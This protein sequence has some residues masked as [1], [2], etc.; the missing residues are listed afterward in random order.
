MLQHSTFK[1]FSTLIKEGS[2]EALSVPVFDEDT[3]L[4]PEYTTETGWHFYAHLNITDEL[5]EDVK[6]R[7]RIAAIYDSY[8]TAARRMLHDRS[9]FVKLLEHQGQMLHFHVD[10]DNS[11]IG[12]NILRGLATLLA[13]Y[14]YEEVFAKR[15]SDPAVD[16]FAMA[17]QYGSSLIFSVPPATEEESAYSQISLGSCA[18]DPAKVVLGKGRPRP[19]HFAYCADPYNGFDK[20]VDCTPFIPGVRKSGVAMENFS[21]TEKIAMDR[22]FAVPSAPASN[23]YWK[24]GYVFRADLDKFTK[25]VAQAFCRNETR[26]LAHDFISFMK[27][28]N[29]WQHEGGGKELNFATSPWA[30]DCCTMVVFLQPPKTPGEALA[31]YYGNDYRISR[32][33]ERLMSAWTKFVGENAPDEKF[34]KWSYGLSF[35]MVGFFDEIINDRG[36]RLLIGKPVHTSN[37]G[38]NLEN[39]ESGD[40]VMH[41]DDIAKLDADLQRTFT[42]TMGNGYRGQEEWKRYSI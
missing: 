23:P 34:R 29:Q 36:Y 40:L 17:A 5:F 8:S 33:P 19:W 32:M 31:A 42:K 7:D 6:A 3:P 13:S 24:R 41:N 12:I 16:D 28:V 22:A 26:T 11:Q 21:T 4:I 25:H 30:G 39:T 1:N 10:C 27:K 20:T 15:N 18:N 14:V 9:T 38:V 35:G 37:V 2:T